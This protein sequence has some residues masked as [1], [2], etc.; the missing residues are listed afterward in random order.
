M[1]ISTIKREGSIFIVTKKPNWVQKILGVKPKTE[2]YKEKPNDRYIHFPSVTVYIS[3]DGKI[4]GPLNS[5]T[6]TLDNWKRKF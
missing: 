1:K 2:K 3:E 4:L 5:I 6:Q